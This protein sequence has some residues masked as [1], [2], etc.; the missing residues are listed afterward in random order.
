MMTWIRFGLCPTRGNEV[1]SLENGV[2]CINSVRTVPTHSVFT[3]QQS[4]CLHLVAFSVK[5]L[6]LLSEP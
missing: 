2:Q 3:M 5:G 6:V 1:V 4:Q